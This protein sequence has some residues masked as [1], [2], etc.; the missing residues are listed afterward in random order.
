MSAFAS[1]LIRPAAVSDLIIVAKPSTTTLAFS[2]LM[3]VFLAKDPKEEKMRETY[4]RT[5]TVPSFEHN[6]C[7]SLLCWTGGGLIKVMK[8]SYD[9][10]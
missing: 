4:C 9:P 2:I 3:N 8:A 1:G 7:C 10:G 5:E 6:R